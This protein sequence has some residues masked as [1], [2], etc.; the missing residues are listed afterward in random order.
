MCRTKN[1]KLENWPAFVIG[2]TPS[3]TQRYP[4]MYAHDIQTVI[5]NPISNV[6]IVKRVYFPFKPSAVS[7]I[8][9]ATFLSCNLDGWFCMF[10]ENL[11]V[12]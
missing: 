9:I 6:Q 8:D 4:V 5:T 1:D 12:P 7:C 11:P 10:N 3:F 2:D